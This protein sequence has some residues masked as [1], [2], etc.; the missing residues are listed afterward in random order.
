MVAR[1]IGAP[2]IR[3]DWLTSEFSLSTEGGAMSE[4]GHREPAPGELRIIQRFVNSANLLEGTDELA[5]IDST[6][7][8]LL[9]SHLI[10]AERP[11][12]EWERQE[13]V[14]L[15]EALRDLASANNGTSLPPG[16]AA[17]LDRA[18][19]RVR[20]AMRL[21]R[22]GKYRLVPEGQGVD[23]TISEVL[24]RA[25]GAMSDGSWLRMKACQRE[26]CRWMF[27]D[28][29]RNRSGVWCSMATCGNRQKGAAYRARRTGGETTVAA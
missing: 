22:T 8:F 11:L 21:S 14:A 20:L 12:R 29:S 27:Y 24:V 6:R 25:L 19:G 23:R 2:V 3:L 15:R 18:A 10:D 28:A 17:V 9:K 26:A 13:L 1:L 7:R 16:S 5:T 4:P